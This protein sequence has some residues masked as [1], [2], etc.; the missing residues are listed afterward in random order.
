MPIETTAQRATLPEVKAVSK[1][2]VAANKAKTLEVYD[3]KTYEK[4]KDIAGIS[5]IGHMTA[6]S[7][8]KYMITPDGKSIPVTAQ[9]WDGM[10]AK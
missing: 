4:I 2:S 9:G 8:G 7:E 3:A 6:P 1:A 5:I 10:R